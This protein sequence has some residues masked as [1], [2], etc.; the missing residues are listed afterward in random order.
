[1]RLSKPACTIIFILLMSASAIPQTQ[2]DSLL[3]ARAQQ[4][5]PFILDSARRSG[6][7][8]RIL[9]TLCFVE[10]RFKIEAVSPTGA[11]GPMQFMPDTAA[12]YG[13]SNPHDPRASIAA[14]A[15]YLRDLLNRFGGRM[16]LALAAYNSGEGTVVSYLTGRPLMLRTGKVINP[17][18]LITNGIPP[19]EETRNYVASILQMTNGSERGSLA[20]RLP[21]ATGRRSSENI[22]NEKKN[23]FSDHS[24]FI[25]LD[26]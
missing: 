11:R 9:W 16:D 7:D 6:I 17:R 15:R 23:K 20:F 19:Y 21:S 12:R 4:L 14:A 5:E 10:S 24:S 18:G 2:Q 22:S 25:D 3:S 26:Q 8:P 13:L 1:M